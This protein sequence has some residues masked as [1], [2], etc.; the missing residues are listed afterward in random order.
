[1][2]TT[3]RSC[4]YYIHTL[5]VLAT[6]SIIFL[7]ITKQRPA[8]CDE[9]CHNSNNFVNLFNYLH[10]DMYLIIVKKSI[11]KRELNNFFRTIEILDHAFVIIHSD[12]ADKELVLG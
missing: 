3:T 8:S 6:R 4:H 2:P 12:C 11:E 1:M 7:K 5:L 10:A 9:F